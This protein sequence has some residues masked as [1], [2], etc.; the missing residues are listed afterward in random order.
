MWEIFD[1]YELK[2][3]DIYLFNFRVLFM[4][5]LSFI[6]KVVIINKSNKTS[7]QIFKIQWCVFRQKKQMIV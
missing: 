6:I 5:D 1:I 4:F 3:V 7:F 2:K